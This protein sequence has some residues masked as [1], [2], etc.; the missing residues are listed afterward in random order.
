MNESKLAS[1]LRLSSLYSPSNN[2]SRLSVC[3]TESTIT[4]YST[5]SPAS[6]TRCCSSKV[7]GKSPFIFTA[8]VA[9]MSPL[10]SPAGSL[11]TVYKKPARSI[12]PVILTGPILTLVM[13]PSSTLGVNTVPACFE[14]SRLPYLVSVPSFIE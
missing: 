7:H 2:L 5:P 6:M 9:C 3:I 1:V 8:F 14:V 11:L 4:P 13:I 10:K 12:A